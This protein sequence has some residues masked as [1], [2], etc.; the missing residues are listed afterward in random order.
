[1]IGDYARVHKTYLGAFMRVLTAAF[2]SVTLAASSALAADNSLL[3]PGKPAG[4]KQA[5]IATVP[6][7]ALVGIGAFVGLLVGITSNSGGYSNAP[8]VSTTATTVTTG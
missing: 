2:L 3:A 8:T 5:D 4:V 7:L 1:M 6:L